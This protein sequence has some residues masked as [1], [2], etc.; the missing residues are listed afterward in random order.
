MPMR[1][2][3][4]TLLIGVLAALMAVVPA[5]AAN[6]VTYP[7]STGEP[8]VKDITTVVVSND[9]K[10]LVTFRINV[11]SLP[12]YTVDVLVEIYVDTDNNAATGSADFGGIDYVIQLFRGE[13][14]LFK[15]DGTAFTRRFGDPPA[16]TLIYN[17]QNGVG[18][19]ISATEL[20]NAKRMRFFVDVLSGLT[21][22][23]VTGE[24]DDT[25]AVVDFAPD[26]GKGF[27]TYDVKLAPARIVF[28]SITKAPATPKAGRTFTVRMAATRSDTG[29]AI[30]NGRVDCTAKAGARN[31]K[32]K[33]ERFVGGQAV[34]VF[35]VPAGTTGRTLRGTITMIFEGKRLTRPFTGRI[36]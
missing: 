3:R 34:C 23:P 1:A 10:G 8:G 14:D 11:P 24:P 26:L 7:D 30:V 36:G 21:F 29:A 25:N 4:G 9:D 22:D 12:Q 15:W 17:W 28:K 6:S 33:S 35:T 27:F 20:G 19:R 31:V 16:T 18:V 32:P 2:L 13:I 5:G